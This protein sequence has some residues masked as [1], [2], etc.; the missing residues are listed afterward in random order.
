MTEN[1]TFSLHLKRQTV[2]L[3]VRGQELILHGFFISALVGPSNQ[4]KATAYP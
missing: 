2:R 4:L 1:I 3:S